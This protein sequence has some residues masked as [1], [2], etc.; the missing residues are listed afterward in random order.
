MTKRKSSVEQYLHSF[1]Y[2]FEVL[3]DVVKP[4]FTESCAGAGNQCRVMEEV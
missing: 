1:S 3:E 4:L 2:K